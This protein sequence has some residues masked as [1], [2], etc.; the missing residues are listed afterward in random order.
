M[1][2]V[3][4]LVMEIVLGV[5]LHILQNVDRR[6]IWLRVFVEGSLVLLVRPEHTF[7]RHAA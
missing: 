6:V 5:L 1:T 7:V 4:V 2:Q 3:L